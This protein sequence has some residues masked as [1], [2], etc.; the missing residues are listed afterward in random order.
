VSNQTGY[1]AQVLIARELACLYA[2]RIIL[3]NEYS[4]A[5]DVKILG[6]NIS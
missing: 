2:F 5:T 1:K 3:S 6:S 4:R